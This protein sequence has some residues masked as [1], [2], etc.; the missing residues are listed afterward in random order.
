MRAGREWQGRTWY[1]LTDGEASF[2]RDG[3]V[4]PASFDRR[5]RP[6]PSI[7]KTDYSDLTILKTDRSHP[8]QGGTS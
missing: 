5:Y 6:L 4:C 1:F 2:G 7:G 3:A 8:F